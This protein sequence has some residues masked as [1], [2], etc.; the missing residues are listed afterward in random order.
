MNGKTKERVTLLDASFRPLVE[1]LLDCGAAVGLVPEVSCGMR[2]MQEQEML[3]EQGRTRPGAKVT[4]AKPG[5]SAHNYGLAVDIWFC[6]K[7][8]SASFDP[9]S[10]QKLWDAAVLVG[11]DKKGL[12][13][14]GN[15]VTFQEKAHFELV[16]WK[17]L[18]KKAEK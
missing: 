16:G 5:E 6:K 9:K 13:W 8:G 3:Y 7:D 4:N 11:L 15:W 14:S 2:T 10:Y 12:S 1:A 17:T 18:I